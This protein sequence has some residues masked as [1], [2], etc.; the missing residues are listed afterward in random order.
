MPSQRMP[1][2]AVALAPLEQVGHRGVALERGAHA[3]LVV[4][5][6]EDD[7]QAPQRG[8]VER[9]AERALVRGA[10]AELAQ[11]TSSVPV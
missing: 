5:D 3:E 8:Q 6:H 9:L 2:D 10:V 11:V 4:G 7:G 1:R